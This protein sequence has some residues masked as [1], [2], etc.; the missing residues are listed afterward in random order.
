MTEPDAPTA[1]RTFDELAVGDAMSITRE[2]G[3]ED[4]ALIATVAGP[5]RRASCWAPGPRWC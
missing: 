4:V 2:L 3:P 1:D 5:T